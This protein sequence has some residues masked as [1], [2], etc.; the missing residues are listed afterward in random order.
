MREM[1]QYSKTIRTNF[2]FIDN[3]RSTN[4]DEERYKLVLDEINDY[5]IEDDSNTV[6]R[7]LINYDF[8]TGSIQNVNIVDGWISK[9]GNGKLYI[10]FDSS[11]KNNSSH[12]FPF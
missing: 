11:E 2:E 8:A 4:T 9:E 5:C 7:L 3:F 10:D 6:E 1:K 12:H